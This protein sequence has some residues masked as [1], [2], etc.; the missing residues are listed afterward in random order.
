MG[1]W[2][3][4]RTAGFG[5]MVGSGVNT[6]DERRD[7]TAIVLAAGKGS[8][9]ESRIHKQYLELEGCPLICHALAAFERSPVNRIILVTGAGETEFCRKEIVEAYGPYFTSL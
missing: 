7:V 6:V 8:R 5:A 2:P 4:R 3:E 9:M 1:R